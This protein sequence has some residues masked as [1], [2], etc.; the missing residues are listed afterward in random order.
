[1]EANNLMAKAL[2]SQARVT[3]FSDEFSPSHSTSQGI[4]FAFGVVGVPVTPFAEA[5]QREGQDC[6]LHFLVSIPL[7][8]STQESNSLRCA[9]SKLLVTL[10]P[11]WAT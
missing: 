10:P 3:F 8:S 11:S 7:L 9:M 4:Q 6:S 1:M 2:K 5:M